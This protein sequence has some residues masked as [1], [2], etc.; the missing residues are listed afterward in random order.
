MIP[1]GWFSMIALSIAT[2]RWRS[3]TSASIFDVSA[4]RRVMVLPQEQGMPWPVIAHA[5]LKGSPGR[6]RGKG[7]GPVAG[8]APSPAP[9]GD[10]PHGHAAREVGERPG[11][12]AAGG[13]PGGH[14]LVHALREDPLH[15]LLPDPRRGHGPRGACVEARAPHPGGAP[16]ARPHEPRAP[17]P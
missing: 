8:L 17:P 13:A 11:P 12:R 16:A 7:H 6:G 3:F 9:D 15:D 10:D 5:I 4:E 1:M 2:W 14:L